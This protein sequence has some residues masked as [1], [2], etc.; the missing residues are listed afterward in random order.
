M[1]PA[2]RQLVTELFDR[3]ATLE[4]APRDP[5]AERAIRDGLRQAPN[6]VY[7]L[8]QTT[9][10]QDEALKR[11]DARIRELEAELGNG[12]EPQRQGGFLDGMRDTSSA[13]ATSRAARC[14]RCGR[15]CADGRAAGFGTG[16]AGS[17]RRAPWARKGPQRPPPAA[18]GSHRRREADRAARSSAP[19]RRPPPA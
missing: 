19:R 9:L 18:S 2:E 12:N 10:V 7:A 17:S 5:E 1:T 13:G 16:S 4:D 8:V 11:A 15:R 14:R 6:A 3:L